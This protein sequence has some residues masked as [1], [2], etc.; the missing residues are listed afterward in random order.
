MK[1][2]EGIHNDSW[3]GPLSWFLLCLLAVFS[4]YLS[5][6]ILSPFIIALLLAYAF[7]PVID[8]LEERRF[9][10]LLAI[11]LVFVFI[12]VI[13]AVFLFFGVPTL[14]D[15]LTRVFDQF[16]VY[17]EHLQKNWLPA[18]ERMFGFKL[19]QT[20]DETLKTILPRLKEDAPA[21]FKPVTTFALSFFTN[22]IGLVATIGNLIIIPFMFYYL[23]RDFDRI[24]V[25]LARFIPDRYRTELD[26]R[27]H[28]IDLSLSGFVRGQLLIILLLGI[29]Y[30]GG[31]SVIGLDIAFAVGIVA[32]IGELVPY[33]GFT[34]GLL[35][36]LTFA[37]LQFQDFIHPL[38]ILLLF[39]GI[40][41]IQGL[42]IAPLIMGK[43]VG[44][45]PLVIIAS[46]Y[47]GGDLF[48]F[49]G[50]LLAVPGAAVLV[51]LLRAFA[52]YYRRS[53]LYLGTPE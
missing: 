4:L 35:L 52:E 43:Q 30:V 8:A 42:A 49:V 31:L 9:P 33:I 47:I 39:G 7:D 36:S 22:T 3:K 27:L 26:K 51:V 19:P 6:S 40:Q 21:I 48:G 1:I 5:K 46:I 14:Q 11:A 28:E 50:I 24:K 20:F 16:P 17:L 13:F 23:L 2:K 53:K 45:H 44:L 32:A 15:Q 29:F 34:V 37:F 12:I 25:S 18:I 41:A 10:R 38:Y